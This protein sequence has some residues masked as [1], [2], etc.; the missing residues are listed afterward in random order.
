MASSFLSVLTSKFAI[1]NCFSPCHSSAG[2]SCGG[3][4]Y[5]LRVSQKL[6]EMKFKKVFKRDHWQAVLLQFFFRENPSKNGHGDLRIEG[7]R[8]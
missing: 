1:P 4:I 2:F 8:A 5:V 6:D 3:F 7:G